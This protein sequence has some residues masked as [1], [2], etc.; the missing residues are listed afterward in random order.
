MLPS[1]VDG[2]DPRYLKCEIRQQIEAENYWELIINK[3]LLKQASENQPGGGSMHVAVK[4]KA[5]LLP[6]NLTAKTRMKV[7]ISWWMRSIGLWQYHFT[8]LNILRSVFHH[9]MT[10]KARKEFL[11]VNVA[12]PG[13]GLPDQRPSWK[14][15]SETE[16]KYGH[17]VS[18]SGV[19]GCRLPVVNARP[20]RWR[21]L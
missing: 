6:I 2:Q 5:T 20:V 11:G 3:P 13:L 14:S 12:F 21:L 1:S 4:K 16:S 7:I 17:P 10:L 9:C 18:L 19:P 15:V 8:S